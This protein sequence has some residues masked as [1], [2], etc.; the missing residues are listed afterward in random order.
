MNGIKLQIGGV[1]REFVPLPALSQQWGLPDEFCIA[2]FEPKD[3]Q[4]LGSLDGAGKALEKVKQQVLRATPRRLTANSLPGWVEPLTGVFR[5]ALVGANEEVG[6]RESEIDF[7]V[8]GFRA[9]TQAVADH[10]IRLS[11]A[12]R[13]DPG[14]IRSQYDYAAIYR[15]WLDESVEVSGMTHAYTHNGARFDVRVIYYAYGRVGLEVRPA[16]GE[17]YY[18]A[19]LA[20]ACPAASYMQELCGAVGERLCEALAGSG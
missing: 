14:L 6:L 11:Y 12:N 8:A 17:T 19:D 13:A 15:A 7:A 10:L 3:W 5:R 1:R 16:G 4:G 18:V 9:I 20:L 2:H